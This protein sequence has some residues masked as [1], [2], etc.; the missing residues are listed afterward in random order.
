MTMRVHIEFHL[1]CSPDLAWNEVVRSSLLQEVSRPLVRFSPQ[2][3]ATL[4]DL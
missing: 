2:G 4:P 3:D 1:P